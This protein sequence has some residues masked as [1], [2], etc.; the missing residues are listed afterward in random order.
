M[1]VIEWVKGKSIDEVVVIK[2]SEIVEEF[3]LLL[4]KI[5]C[6]ILVEDVIKVV[7]VDYKKKY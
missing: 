2:N 5:Y 6:L 4:V 7:V 1:L 3:E